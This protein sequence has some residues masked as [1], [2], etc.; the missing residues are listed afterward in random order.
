MKRQTPLS[1]PA[2]GRKTGDD[3]IEELKERRPPYW[4][5]QG[6]RKHSLDTMRDRGY[7]Q[8]DLEGVSV[9]PDDPRNSLGVPLSRVTRV[10]GEMTPQQLQDALAELAGKDLYNLIEGHTAQIN[11][12]QRGEIGNRKT[13]DKSIANGFSRGEH[14]SA[15]SHVE[16][17]WK[18]AA[19]VWQGPDTKNHMPDVE[20]RRYVSALRLDGKDV[21]AW[22][23]VKNTHN[24]LHL[25]SLELMDTEK[26]ETE[27]KKLREKVD[28]DSRNLGPVVIHRSF[29]EI[30]D[31]LNGPVKLPAGGSD[32]STL[33]QIAYHGTPYRGIEETGFST[34]SI[35]TGE[36]A[37]VHGWGLYFAKDKKIADVHYRNA[38]TTKRAVVEIDGRV[39]RYDVGFGRWVDKDTGDAMEFADS[40]AVARLD[41]ND[42]DVQKA[43]ASLQE[44]LIYGPY[45][46]TARESVERLKKGN[47]VYKKSPGQL[48]KVDI[49]DD[50]VLLDEQKTFEQQP[51]KVRSALEKIAEQTPLNFEGKTG[52]EIYA[53]LKKW[54]LNQKNASLALN[55][56][57]I[58]GITYYGRGDGRC[59]VIFDDKAIKIL[60]TY[61]EMKAQEG[62]ARGAI[63][64]TDDSRYLIT[65]F[66]GADL[67][68][69]VHEL[70][71]V[72]FLQME[73]AK[74]H[75][76]A[77][78]A[79]RFE[80]P[81]RMDG[82][83]GR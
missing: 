24:K 58:K 5:K 25:Y 51:E 73:E 4:V 21:F 42:N 14:F 44:D 10:E 41:E 75:G 65:L 56:A 29:E 8:P 80:N 82:G 43:I 22:L 68:T 16:N 49:P 15:S 30:I 62:L 60:E 3:L 59:F 40:L 38:L 81:A 34:D 70:G 55:K 48:F 9:Q 78:G 31:R 76:T 77:A 17:L 64:R 53:S 45:P 6:R 69:L 50:D 2:Y 35:G 66:K 52:K 33:L 39:Y 20:M 46:K 26:I 79:G 36:G 71:H 74:R 63:T 23:T 13:S 37:Q 19:L 7:L 11:N 61:Y 27:I 32:L 67:S 72:Y 83:S 57:G 18:W 47:I 28:S 54:Y 12:R 1:V